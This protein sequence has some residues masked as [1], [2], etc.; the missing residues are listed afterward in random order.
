MSS[1]IRNLA[2]GALCTSPKIFRLG[3]AALQ[4]MA[5]S[6][7]AFLN[8]DRNPLLRA[9]VKPIIY[10]QFCAGV[11]KSEIQSTVSRIKGTGFSGVLLA[12]GKEIE[13]N[14]P[15]DMSSMT[16]FEK[17]EAFDK[18][19]DTWLQGNLQTLDMIG[20]RDFLAVKY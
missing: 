13:V 20:D 5:H 14:N 1:L 16:Q 10:D 2:F 15:R 12:Y 6:Q 17:S 4:T 7:S 11:T 19:V 9:I 3:F 8:P 18:D